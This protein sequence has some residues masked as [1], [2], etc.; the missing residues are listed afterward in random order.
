MKYWSFLEAERQAPASARRAGR[1]RTIGSFVLPSLCLEP[2]EVQVLDL[3]VRYH[4]LFLAPTE[5]LVLCDSFLF[6]EVLSFDQIPWLIVVEYRA[7]IL[8]LSLSL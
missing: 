8:A 5:E 4:F 1:R 2:G 3:L 6:I 7:L